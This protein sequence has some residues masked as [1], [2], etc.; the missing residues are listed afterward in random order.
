MFALF[1]VE[2]DHFEFFEGLIDTPCPGTQRT[3]FVPAMSPFDKNLLTPLLLF[4]VCDQWDHDAISTRVDPR[5]L[6]TLDEALVRLKGGRNGPRLLCFED[7]FPGTD[8]QQ[9]QLLAT[10]S[11]L[12]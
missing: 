2:R 4:S 12:S 6:F 7:D 3:A 9:P 1:I 10:H 5:L 8:H 11:N